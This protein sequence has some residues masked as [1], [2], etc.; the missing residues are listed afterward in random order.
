MTGL[1]WATYDLELHSLAIELNGAD[2]LESVSNMSNS[3]PVLITYK[4]NTNGRDVGLGVRVIGETKQQA[5]LS[6][7]G[8]SDQQELEQVIV[9]ANHM[10]SIVLSI[11]FFS[12]HKLRRCTTSRRLSGDPGVVCGMS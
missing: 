6:D 7:A 3:V 4:V 8:I 9:S 10:V 12:C 2:F 11:P 1:K 5:R